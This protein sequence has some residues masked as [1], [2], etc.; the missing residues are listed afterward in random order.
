MAREPTPY[1]KVITDITSV[2]STFMSSSSTL[3]SP[4]QGSLLHVNQIV[5]QVLRA[6]KCHHGQIFNGLLTP[7]GNV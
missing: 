1:Y 5:S 2:T 7:I 6:S 3:S 4:I